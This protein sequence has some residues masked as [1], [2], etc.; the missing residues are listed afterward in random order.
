MAPTIISN[1]TVALAMTMTE[2]TPSNSTF[3]TQNQ[4]KIGDSNEWGIP[5]II[6]VLL[7]ILAVAVALPGAALAIRKLHKCKI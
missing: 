4:S 3:T 5:V 1:F 6:G 2:T 7:A